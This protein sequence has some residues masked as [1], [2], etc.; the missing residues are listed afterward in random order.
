ML[1]LNYE[2]TPVLSD[3]TGVGLR[4]VVVLTRTRHKHIPVLNREVPFILNITAR[5]EGRY[6]ATSATL[7]KQ[8]FLRSRGLQ[9]NV[10]LPEFRYVEKRYRR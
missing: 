2:G 9:N 6:R 3:L 1:R 4:W 8:C 7:S 10:K 5:P